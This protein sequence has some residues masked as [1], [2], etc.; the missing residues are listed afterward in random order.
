M[1]QGPLLY[2]PRMYLV[3]VNNEKIRK[4]AQSS[5][6]GSNMAYA[7][8]DGTNSSSVKMQSAIR[9]FGIRAVLAVWMMA[10]GPVLAHQ[11][12]S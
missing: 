6:G 10:A 1:G 12:K 7:I 2:K 4:T 8:H 3:P 11:A 5:A 9:I